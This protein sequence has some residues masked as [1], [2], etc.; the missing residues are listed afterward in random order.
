MTLGDK[1]LAII[2]NAG[3]FNM[4]GATAKLL[5]APGS[6]PNVIGNGL[7]LTPLSISVDGLTATYMTT[8]TDFAESGPWQVQLQITLGGTVLTSAPAEIFVNPRY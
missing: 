3:G 1:G 8:G 2:I 6:N 5:A 4:T 7:V